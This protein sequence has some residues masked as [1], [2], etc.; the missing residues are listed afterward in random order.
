VGF[1]RRHRILT[2]SLAVGVV[3][4]GL[5]TITGIAV[6]Q[7]AHD[8][9]ASRIDRV[10]LIAVLG[11]AQYDGDPSPVFRG[12]LQHAELL[13][14]REFA[15]TILVLGGGQPGDA[16]T[17]GDAGRAWLI[18]QGVPEGDVFAAPRG[19][20]T[21][22]SLEG[23]VE[24]MHD[25]GLRTVFLVSDPWH[26]LRVRRMARDLGMDAYVSATFHS[27]AKSQ[28]TRLSGYARETFAYL[29]YRAVGA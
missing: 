16:S 24:F 19:N 20:T 7:S 21:L 29:Y 14:E 22:E 1:V 13:Y 2:A 15:P 8:D 9:E 10:D 4:L 27:A 5:I 26:N 25:R 28:W 6:W 12:R 11:A 18:G 23:A 3:A 17:E